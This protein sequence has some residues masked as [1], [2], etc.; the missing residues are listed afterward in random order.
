LIGPGR[1]AFRE[2]V[3]LHTFLNRYR[4]NGSKID[5][6]FLKE[7]LERLERFDARRGR[8]PSA[9][10]RPPPTQQTVPAAAPV[11][12]TTAPP[13]TVPAAASHTP[14]AS[15]VP[16]VQ[17]PIKP[18][19]RAPTILPRMLKSAALPTTPGAPLSSKWD[20]V[21]MQAHGGPNRS[22][23]AAKYVPRKVVV[24]KD[25]ESNEGEGE[26]EESEDPEV[27]EVQ[28]EKR[29]QLKAT[30]QAH[31]G[32]NRSAAAAKYV[33]RKVVVR[34]DVESDE[35]EGEGEE[36]EDPE[37]VEVQPR[38]LGELE[39]EEE[40]EEDLSLR[41]D[42]EEQ[43]R[44]VLQESEMEVDEE[45]RPVTHRDKGKGKARAP[46]YTDSE[47]ETP[48]PKTPHPRSLTSAAATKPDPADSDSSEDAEYYHPACSTCQMAG[49]ACRKRG[50]NMACLWCNRSKRACQYAT[51][52]KKGKSKVVVESD[53]EEELERVVTDAAGP[54]T[55]GPL[56]SG[57]RG[58]RPAAKKAVR[59]IQ[60]EAKKR[61]SSAKKTARRAPTAAAAAA[62]DDSKL[63]LNF[64]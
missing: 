57:S 5:P 43:V 40:A 10:A 13:P 36:S 24:R 62:P 64:P 2:K 30:V 54:E 61:P 8:G 29:G 44:Q 4:E 39:A 51:K 22:A 12:S 27:V 42:V 15:G 17:K 52:Q 58:A 47:V 37:V 45:P 3:F 11:P 25:V 21:T 48:K 35:G 26:G 32:P 19:D 59:A 49:R 33:P 31:G 50:K 55:D 56:P 60:K 20:V 18:K 9:P 63:P 14:A 1:A 6:T 23:A 16:K 28:P 46:T 34:K 41:M 53:A 7:M 38:K